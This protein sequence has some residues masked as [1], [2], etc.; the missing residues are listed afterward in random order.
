M[1]AERRSFKALP[2]ASSGARFAPR[3][4]PAA[5]GAPSLLD[6]DP[7]SQAALGAGRAP[8]GESPRHPGPRGCV[9]V[10]E[11]PMLAGAWAGGNENNTAGAAVG[12]EEGRLP[13]CQ[14]PLGFITFWNSLFQTVF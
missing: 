1:T 5:P 12:M 4:A 10:K 11:P 3:Q 7:G 6:G 8:L 9:M 13:G 2:E 14:T